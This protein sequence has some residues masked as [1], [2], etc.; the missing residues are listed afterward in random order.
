MA[1]FSGI[2]QSMK[3]SKT[4]HGTQGLFDGLNA[5]RRAQ[6][7]QYLMRAPVADL[8]RALDALQ[9][10]PL[11]TT[12]LPKNHAIV[13]LGAPVNA[14]GTPSPSILQRTRRA[15]EVA[16]AHPDAVLV[17]TG[18]AVVNRFT[19]AQSMAEQLVLLG[20]NPARIY[21]EPYART[22]LDNAAFTMTLLESVW[23]KRALNEAQ[24]TII[25]EPFHAPRALRLFAAASSAYAVTPTL[26]FAASARAAAPNL[27]PYERLVEIGEKI[28]GED[29]QALLLRCIEEKRRL[30]NGW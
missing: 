13:V 29:F 19:E 1:V 12:A 27:P 5:R 2:F 24:L 17:V 4:T 15:A 7:C 21:R 26:R 28:A 8:N 25:T 18:G 6:L 11:D 30:A 23:P 3:T 22:T 16:L 20:I 10:R 14:D 9:S